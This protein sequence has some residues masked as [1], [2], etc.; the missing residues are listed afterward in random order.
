MATPPSATPAPPTRSG[1]GCLLTLGLLPVVVIGGLVIGTVLNREDD[2]NAEVSVTLE[3]GTLDGREW[4][5]AAERDVEGSTCAFLYTGDEQLT[6]ACTL[7]PQAA[8]FGQQ[9]VVFG[10]AGAGRSVRVALDTGA[11]VSIA[12]VVAEGLDGRFYVEVLDGV[13]EATGFAP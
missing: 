4:R 5:V 7:T 1:P 11:V 12:T 3:E 2:P 8:S 9:T 6:G 13:V 10:R